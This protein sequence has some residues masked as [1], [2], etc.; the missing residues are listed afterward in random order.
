MIEPSF[1][2]LRIGLEKL[3]QGK[4]E[5]IVGYRFPLHTFT[6][7]LMGADDGVEESYF[8]GEPAGLVAGFGRYKTMDL[9]LE[10]EWVLGQKNLLEELKLSFFLNM[11]RLT[12][13]EIYILKV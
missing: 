8:F 12:N 1:P 9:V 7:F 4:I 3:T 13:L 6:L 11:K 5:E 2:A 10:S